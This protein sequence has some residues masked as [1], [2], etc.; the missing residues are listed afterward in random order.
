MST[1]GDEGRRPSP[2]DM[3]EVELAEP[4]GEEEVRVEVDPFPEEPTKPDQ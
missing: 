4:V 2:E 3:F 1:R